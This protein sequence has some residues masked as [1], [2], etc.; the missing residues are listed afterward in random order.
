M[1][2][3]GISRRRFLQIAGAGMAGAALAGCTSGEVAVQP[4]VAPGV[5]AP[6][7]TFTE[8]TRTLSGDLKVLMWSH[9]VPA[10]DKWFDPFVQ[11]WGSKSRSTTSTRPRSRPAPRLRSKPA[12]GHD[13]IQYIA[14]FSQFEPSVV[15]L[16]DV[17]QEAEK[18]A[19]QDARRRS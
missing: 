6:S 11:E 1:N 7:T 16:K 10:S 5:P 18:R 4:Q 12:R 9:F 8:P 14:T 2:M 13:L 15:D 19:R 3:Y 17:V